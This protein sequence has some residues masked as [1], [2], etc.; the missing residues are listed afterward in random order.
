MRPLIF[1]KRLL[2]FLLFFNLNSLANA[3]EEI[4]TKLVSFYKDIRPIFQA[5][6][7][8][9]H[10]PSKDKGKYIM[11]DFEKLIK[12]D[13]DKLKVVYTRADKFEGHI[14]I[15]SYKCNKD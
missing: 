13:F 9:C 10:Q 5:N 2:V 15:S 8:G 12:Q 7:Q 6:C 3:D 1:L 4:K 11:T 14:A